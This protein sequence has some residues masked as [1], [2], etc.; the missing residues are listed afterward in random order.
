MQLVLDDIGSQMSKCVPALILNGLDRH[1]RGAQ[2]GG[3]KFADASFQY[4]YQN[5]EA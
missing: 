4:I 1:V 2:I 5:F 3:L